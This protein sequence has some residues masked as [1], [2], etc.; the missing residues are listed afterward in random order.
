MDNAGDASTDRRS[1]HPLGC[2]KESTMIK[3][4]QFAYPLIA[5]FSLAAAVAAHAE[6]PTVDDTATQVWSQTKTRAQVQ[7]ELL[8]ARADGTTKVWSSSYNP[9]ALAKSLKTREEVRAEAVAA[10]ASGESAA[11][12]GED[13]GSFRLAQRPA[14]R[15]ASQL[16]AGSAT[17]SAQ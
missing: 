6:S 11:L 8:Q 9:L 5:V 4:S 12:A 10:L 2:D 3:L 14:A 7:A 15:D 13:S 1:T 17:R 16:L